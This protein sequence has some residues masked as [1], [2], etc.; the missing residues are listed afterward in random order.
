MESAHQGLRKPNV[1]RTMLK[2]LASDFPT[3][4]LITA[5]WGS[6]SAL[7]SSLFYSPTFSPTLSERYASIALIS[8][9]WMLLIKSRLINGVQLCVPHGKETLYSFPVCYTALV[10]IRMA[11]HIPFQVP[12]DFSFFSLYE[13]LYAGLLKIIVAVCSTASLGL[14]VIP[15]K[16][17]VFWV[18]PL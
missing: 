6:Q 13:F 16:M 1:P 3:C 17:S 4:F 9:N 14:D 7:T 18:S 10:L 11:I 8:N 15:R 2:S 12:H 5:C